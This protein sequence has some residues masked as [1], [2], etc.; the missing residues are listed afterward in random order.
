AHAIFEGYVNEE[1]LM[2][3]EYRFHIPTYPP[4][5]QSFTSEDLRKAITKNKWNPVSRPPACGPFWF[6]FYLWH[7][8]PAILSL[9][10]TNQGDLNEQA[11]VSIFRDGLRILPYGE[12]DDDW[13]SLDQERY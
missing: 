10:G 2:E 7:R 4:R 1:G 8:T 5:N 13:L 6:Y 3:A 9:S 12:R 11:G